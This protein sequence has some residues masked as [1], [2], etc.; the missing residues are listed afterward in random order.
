MGGV[1]TRT[2][3]E[4][5]SSLYLRLC[6]WKPTPSIAHFQLTRSEIALIAGR[7]IDFLSKDPMLMQLS[8]P[9]HVVGDIHGRI[10]DLQQA[11]RVGGPPH[12]HRYLFLGD[13]VDRGKNSIE[14][15]CLLLL[16]KILYP[17][18]VFLLRGNHEIA[19]VCRA[20][21][22]YSE[23]MALYDEAVWT[24]FVDVFRYI[25][26]AAL[27]CNQVFCV[28]GGISQ[29]CDNIRIIHTFL[30]PFDVPDQGIAADF[31]WSDPSTEH[32]GYQPSPRG[33]GFL[34]GKEAVHD[35]FTKTGLKMI[36]RAHQAVPDGIEFPF[37]PDR[38]VITVFSSANYSETRGDV[39]AILTFDANLQYRCQ[40]YA[41]RR[42]TGEL[43]GNERDG[44]VPEP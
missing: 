20:G 18:H 42:F 15:F 9:I 17:N 39:A 25:P 7:G 4:T 36:C 28:H 32:P 12:N 33:S 29:Y 26:L 1:L 5:I 38:S 19:G 31:L 11:I 44:K 27:I 41:S 16:L 40:Y 6:T 3:D 23:C 2:D 30:R 35:F 24:Q 8:A 13:Y 37:D 10:T 34:Y 21:G 43:P 14:S 22:F